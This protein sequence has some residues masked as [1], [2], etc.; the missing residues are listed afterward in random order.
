MNTATHREYTNKPINKSFP[1]ETWHGI[2]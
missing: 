1:L 2:N